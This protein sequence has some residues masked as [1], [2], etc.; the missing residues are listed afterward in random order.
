MSVCEDSIINEHLI[1]LSS[2]YL[3]LILLISNV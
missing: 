2:V 3:L 1:R